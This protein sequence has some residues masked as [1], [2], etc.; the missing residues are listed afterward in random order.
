MAYRKKSETENVAAVEESEVKAEKTSAVDK[1][2]EELKAQLEE[3]KAQMALMA[4]MVGDKPAQTVKSNREITFVSMVPGTLVLKGTTI[5]KIEG[6]F[7]SRSIME[8]EAE[9]ILSNMNNAIRNGIVYIADAQFVREHNLEAV[10]AYLITDK[11]LKELLS[12]NAKYVVDVYKNANDA[13]KQIIIDMVSE[14]KLNGQ[15]VD[16]NILIE[17]GKLCHKD[18]ISIEPI[19]E[20]G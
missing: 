14:K 2:K 7:N 4:Q 15:E 9:A 5:W 8:S 18:L 13:Q 16:A 20:E 11:Q 10:Y 12:M 1:E 6:Q 17:L 3:L 19:E